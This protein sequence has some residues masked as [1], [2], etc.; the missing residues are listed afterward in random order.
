MLSDRLLERSRQEYSPCS[1]R[2]VDAAID[3][4]EILYAS[5]T[6]SI[7]ELARLMAQGDASCVAIVEEL[8]APNGEDRP[9]KPL[10]IVTARDLVKCQS[11]HGQNPCDLAVEFAPLVCVS[12][13]DTLEIACREMQQQD[14]QYLGVCGEGGEWMGLV[15]PASLL[16]A[17]EPSQC[18]PSQ[19]PAPTPESEHLERRVGQLE[20]EKIELLRDLEAKVERQVRQRTLELQR[21]VDVLTQSVRKCTQAQHSEIAFQ[22]SEEKFRQLAENIREVFFI[23]DAKSFQAIYISPAFEEIWGFSSDRIYENSFAWLDVVHREDRDRFV[24][25]AQQRGG[26]TA[27]EREYRIVRPDGE[28]RWIRERSFP[29]RDGS[30]AIYRLAGIAEDITERKLAQEAL[31]QLNQQLETIVEQRTFLLKQ[32]NDRLQAHIG[33]RQ[34]IESEIATRAK[35][36][37]IV[38]ELGQQALS[39]MELHPLVRQLVLRVAAGLE[40]DYCKMLEILPDARSL[41]TLGIQNDSETK[42]I[43]LD[44]EPLA[45]G[46]WQFDRIIQQ[47][48]FADCDAGSSLSVAIQGKTAC[49]GILGAYSRQPR[50]FTQDDIHFLQSAANVLAAAIERQQSDTALRES[51]AQYRRTIDTAAEGIWTLNAE[52]HTTF[53]N[54]RMAKML[55]YSPEEMLGRPMS[56]FMEETCWASAMENFGQRPQDTTEQHDFQFRAQDGSPLWAIVS[57]TPI[58]T[59]TG[60]YSGALMMLTD[61]TDRKRAEAAVERQHLKSKLFAEIALKICRS[62][63][64][65]DILQTTVTEVQK[66]LDCDR[67]SIYRLLPDGSGHAIAE[68]VE[69]GHSSLLDLCWPSNIFESDRQQCFLEGKAMAIADVERADDQTAP[70]LL[71]LM[72]KWGVRAKLVVPILQ[73]DR[74]WGFI[75]AHQCCAPRA[76]TD[77]ET[78]LLQHLADRVGIALAQAQLLAA[79][80]KSEA[81]FRAMFEQAAVGI[82]QNDLDGRFIRC[83][84]KSGDILGYPCEELLTKMLGEITH[85]KDLVQCNAA[86]ARLLGDEIQ[87]FSMEQRFTRKNG[88]I[89]WVNL[90]VSLV[91]APLGQP[92]YF[93][94]VMEDISDRKAALYER[95]QAQA[96][97]KASLYEK[98]VLLKEIHHR[99][100]NNLYIISNLLD[101]QSETLEDE[102]SKQLFADSQ[103]RLQTMALIHEQLYKSTDLATVD[104]TNYVR[105]LVNNLYYSYDNTNGKIEIAIDADSLLLNLETAI[106]CGLLINELITN[107]FKYAFPESRSGTIAI[108]INCD[109]HENINLIVRDD[110]IG[111]PENL[112][113]QNTSSLGLRL[114]NIL[115][116]Q[117]EADIALDRQNGT[118]FHLVFRELKYQERF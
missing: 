21:Q 83:N 104:F 3:P 90:T 38:A 4:Q 53:V 97:L 113:W 39:G 6:A 70:N 10:G 17:I 67:V 59:A 99:V 41:L 66:I 58:F 101:L 18:S 32:A 44:R 74:I 47:P 103:N 72:R 88:S 23:H 109:R 16:G 92:D 73:H 63:Q 31:E 12:P 87:T 52:R 89:V 24:A 27:F 111:I 114:V 95:E 84:Q 42:G 30:G 50:T 9:R 100:K 48:K 94:G 8:Q 102:A 98:E 110:G 107:S 62:L 82:V 57:A 68:V 2:R 13:T 96:K 36:Q 61:I 29:V 69:P 64:L 37:A 115:A 55:G 105:N 79:R 35:Q 106:P 46:S 71:A 22:E 51:E 14:V 81:R 19:P 112:D 54:P 118:S 25:E 75:V 77:L 93:L 65:D 11:L 116:E 78:E 28:I 7:S 33:E 26:K 5:P 85:P 34:Q 56:D 76:W 40:V 45:A 60:Q 1:T 108:Q 49:F 80:Q 43:L 20:L 15:T 91:R 117:L 86:L